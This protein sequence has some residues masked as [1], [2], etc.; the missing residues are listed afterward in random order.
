M[1]GLVDDAALDLCNE[2]SSQFGE[3]ANKG[4]S[5]KIS[6]AGILHGPNNRLSLVRIT[7]TESTHQIT[8]D[9]RTF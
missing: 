2:W 9:D 1:G 8:V 7:K 5:G 4:N 3:L 6:S